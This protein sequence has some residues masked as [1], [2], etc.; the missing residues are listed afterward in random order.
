MNIFDLHLPAEKTPILDAAGER[1]NEIHNL[2][3]K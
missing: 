2:W 3:F 1:V